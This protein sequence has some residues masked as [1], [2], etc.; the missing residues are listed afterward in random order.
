M[1]RFINLLKHI[2]EI[3]ILFFYMKKLNDKID[4]TSNGIKYTGQY[5]DLKNISIR[6][7]NKKLELIV[8]FAKKEKGNKINILD[9]GAN[10]GVYSIGFA[11]NSN[12]QVFSFEPYNKT[13]EILNHNINQ[14]NFKN[15]QCYNFG[16]LNENKELF[17][18]YPQHE[19]KYMSFFKYFDKYSLGSKTIY[20]GQKFDSLEKKSNFYIGD[21]ISEIKNLDALGII[22]I[23]VEGAEF[24]VLKGL[25]KTLSLY[26]P[27]IC[28]ETN[29]GYKNNNNDFDSIILFLS[30]IGY[31]NIIELSKVLNK[32]SFK[33]PLS[34]QAL[35][36]QAHQF[37]RSTDLLVY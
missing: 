17:L 4:I 3:V 21:N 24:E 37:K 30:K 6:E 23:D 35:I 26:K 33:N 8:D 36:S 27:M 16:L 32:S 13:F 22:K 20:T 25:E 2:K 5:F 10:I 34:V 12:T 15:I 11:L 31:E 9:I 7:Y 18:G 1:N 19:T 28:L 14:N 29:S